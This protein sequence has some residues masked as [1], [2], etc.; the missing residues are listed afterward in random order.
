MMGVG[1]LG[2]GAGEGDR[3]LGR[4]CDGFA[5]QSF[6]TRVTSARLVPS[7]FRRL[8]QPYENNV[9]PVNKYDFVFLPDA[10]KGFRVRKGA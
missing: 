6:M 9:R 7:N 5:R 3:M 8:P 10:V 1:T 2:P 4:C